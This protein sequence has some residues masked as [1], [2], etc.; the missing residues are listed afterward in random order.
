MLRQSIPDQG[1][2]DLNAHPS[3]P[4]VRLVC[5]SCNRR[6]IKCDKHSPCTSCVESRIV[7][8]PVQRARLPRGRASKVCGSNSEKELRDRISKIERRMRNLNAPKTQDYD[9]DPR[10]DQ[11]KATASSVSSNLPVSEPIASGSD[12]FSITRQPTRSD[13][14]LSTYAPFTRHYLSAKYQACPHPIVW[15]ESRQR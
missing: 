3:R 11:G 6:K 13:D 7:C 14:A 5:Q 8:V 2:R 9:N 12:Q 1:G 15:E 10:Y 4:E